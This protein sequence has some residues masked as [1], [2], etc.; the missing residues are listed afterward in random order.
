MSDC[1]YVCLQDENKIARFAMDRETGQLAAQ[2][3]VP[4]QGGPSVLAISP[5]GGVLYVGHRSVP[6][7]SSFQIER[8]SGQ[9]KL[10]GTVSLEH[11]P[12]FL[13]TDGTGRYL[14]SAYYQGGYATVHR[15]GE[16]GAV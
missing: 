8:S 11:A 16:D 2:G 1:L 6:A 13:A 12:T 3:D 15:L 10:L 4:A 14:L 7:V 5:D 9:L